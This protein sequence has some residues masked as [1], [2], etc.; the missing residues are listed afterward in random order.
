MKVS[1]C[2]L[3]TGTWKTAAEWSSDSSWEVFSLFLSSRLLSW[4][5]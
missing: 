5:G 3:S 4:G 1:V 2:E